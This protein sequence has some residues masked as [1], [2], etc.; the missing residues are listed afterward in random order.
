[1]AKKKAK[2]QVKAPAD[3]ALTK[4]QVN[5]LYVI[6]A[7]LQQE[8]SP[9][10]TKRASQKFTYALARTK[11]YL[12]DEVDANRVALKPFDEAR[13]DACKRF[14]S[15]DDKG[16]PVMV[17]RN[18][19]IK[20]MEEFEVEVAKLKEEH[21]DPEKFLD[22]PADVQVHKVALEDVPDIPADWMEVLL[23]MIAEDGKE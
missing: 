3:G 11:A 4:R 9:P 14:A 21:G 12:Q 15:K 10:S 13:L 18:F 1:M 2:K 20:N 19:D 16:E 22:L 7:A 23:P 8:F 5:M 6:I 17:G